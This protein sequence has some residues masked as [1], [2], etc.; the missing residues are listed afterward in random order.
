MS[1]KW[2]HWSEIVGGVAG[3]LIVSVIRQPTPVLL[4]IVG[5]LAGQVV[6]RTIRNSRM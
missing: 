1:I 5:F 6:V 3:V 4:G 2:F